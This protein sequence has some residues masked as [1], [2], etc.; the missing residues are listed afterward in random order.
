MS[1][2]FVGVIDRNAV[3]VLFRCD[4]PDDYGDV[5]LDDRARIAE[6]LGIPVFVLGRLESLSAIGED[7][8]RAAGWVRCPS[9]LSEEQGA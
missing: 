5:R 2:E 9:K 7:D 4:D 1:A 8:M 3:A 6:S